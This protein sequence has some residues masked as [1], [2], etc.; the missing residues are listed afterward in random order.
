MALLDG[1]PRS[2][3][4]TAV[5]STVLG[6][7]DEPTFQHILELAPSRLHMNFLRSVTGRLRDEVVIQIS[8]TGVGM[9]AD[10]LSKLF[11]PFVT[12]GNSHGTGL[13]MASPSRSWMRI[14]E[15]SR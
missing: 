14:R 4:A 13:G 15:P 2:A 6:T 3:M 7:V 5:S 1:Q 9:P 12:Y 10:V 11:E 8:D